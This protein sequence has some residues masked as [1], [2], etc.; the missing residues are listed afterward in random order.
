MKMSVQNSDKLTGWGLTVLRVVTG[1]VFLMHGYQKV[2]VFGLDG[3]EGSFTQMGI[4]LPAVSAVLVSAL[5]LLGGIALIA[6]A[7]TR[8]VAVPLA[9]TMV[10]AILQ[11]HLGAGF[12]A[13][14]GF[15]FP[16]MLL[17]GLIGLGLAGPGALAVDNLLV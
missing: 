10:V 14:H 11:V 16:L 4:P 8:L 17:A 13:P 6:G 7:L 3:V 5:E 2:F 12:F 15:E 1:I 9:V